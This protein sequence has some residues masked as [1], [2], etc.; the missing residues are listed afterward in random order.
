MVVV[1]EVA[2]EV[3]KQILAECLYVVGSKMV[4]VS[5]EMKNGT[6]LVEPVLRTE[7]QPVAPKGWVS[8]A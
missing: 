5:L 7:S 1:K 3:G 4:Q 2:L 8:R 6:Q